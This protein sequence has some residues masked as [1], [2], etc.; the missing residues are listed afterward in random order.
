MLKVAEKNTPK[1][2][3]LDKILAEYKASLVQHYYEKSLSEQLL[4]SLVSD[5]EIQTFYEATKDEHILKDA[6]ARCFFITLPIN[7]INK[8]DVKG[9]W[10]MDKDLDYAKLK[11]YSE[12]YAI[13]YILEDSSWISK[14]DL[15]AQLPSGTLNQGLSKGKGFNIEKDGIWY[16]LN[17]KEVV[18]KGQQAPVSFVRDKAIRYILHKRKIELVENIAS[19]MYQRELNKKNVI[20]YK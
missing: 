13:T 2:V 16:L 17:I 19:E 15:A 9:W 20:I 10:K 5:T 7:T 11:E 3:D 1:D 18:A 12:K 4:D 8:D 6:I 14:K